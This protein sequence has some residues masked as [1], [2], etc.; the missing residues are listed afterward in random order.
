[1]FDGPHALD[2]DPQERR[3]RLRLA[4]SARIGPVTFHEALAHFGSARAACQRLATCADADI[5][6]EE[7][8][9]AKVGGKAGGRFLVMG[10]AAYPDAL[11]AVP[12]APPVLSAI[13]DLAL[14]GRPTLA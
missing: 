7:T 13:G 9:L 1:M 12:G 2:L 6:R 5:D 10:D 4:R 3:A 14:L 11:A 8:R